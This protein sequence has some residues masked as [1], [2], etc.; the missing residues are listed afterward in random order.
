MIVTVLTEEHSIFNVEP[1]AFQM[2]P[3]RLAIVQT[4]EIKKNVSLKEVIMTEAHY[5]KLCQLLY[6]FGMFFY[7]KVYTKRRLLQPFSSV[8]FGCLHTCSSRW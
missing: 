6:I 4:K 5:V 3:L 2:K 7:F 8:M 1:H